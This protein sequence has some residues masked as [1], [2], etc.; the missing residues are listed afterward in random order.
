MMS[1]LAGAYPVETDNRAVFS[2][3]SIIQRVSTSAAA[4]GRPVVGS[5]AVAV[6]AVHPGGEVAIKYR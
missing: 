2:N 6:V 5:E 4:A 1:C 3:A